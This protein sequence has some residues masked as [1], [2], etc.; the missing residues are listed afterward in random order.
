MFFDILLKMNTTSP[1]QKASENLKEIKRIQDTLISQGLAH[2]EDK[3]RAFDLSEETTKLFTDDILKRKVEKLKNPSSPLK[4]YAVIGGFVSSAVSEQLKP[5]IFLIEEFVESKKVKTDISNETTHIDSQVDGEN[6]HLFISE[7]GSNRHAHIIVDHR[8]NR[9]LREY[10]SDQ[11]PGELIASVEA[12]IVLK[13]G[14][15]VNV[16]KNSMNFGEKKSPV[17]DV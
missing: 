9:Q 6:Q 2:P 7:K 5:W 16:T 14:E 3:Q 11:D 1:Y 10:G 17:P 12:T 4:N 8:G 13:N 15:T